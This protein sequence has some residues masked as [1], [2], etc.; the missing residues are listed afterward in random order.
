MTPDAATF[1]VVASLTVTLSTAAELKKVF[2][3]AAM[4]CQLC[5]QRLQFLSWFV[6]CGHCQAGLVHSPK[7]LTKVLS[8]VAWVPTAPA[9][10]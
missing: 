5:P 1:N 8:V 4:L 9:R 3:S 10:L 7:I 6:P 2:L